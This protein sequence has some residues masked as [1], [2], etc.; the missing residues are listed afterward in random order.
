MSA[1]PNPPV[2][3]E[4]KLEHFR[5]AT[6]VLGG[7]FGILISASADPRGS[8]IAALALTI[9]PYLLSLVLSGFVGT[10]KQALEL[11]FGVA[12]ASMLAGLLCLPH[13]AKILA[14]TPIWMEMSAT[15][16]YSSLFGEFRFWCGVRV[17]LGFLVSLLFLLLGCGASVNFGE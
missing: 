13:W 9:F 2:V 3:R 16:A 15:R 14:F 1:A 12:I 7:G 8:A 17:T 5:L 6:V 4:S 10:R 11:G